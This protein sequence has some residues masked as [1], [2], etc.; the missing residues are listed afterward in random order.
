MRI[1]SAQ[2]ALNAGESRGYFSTV[3]PGEVGSIVFMLHLLVLKGDVKPVVKMRSM[4]FA[5]MG[6]FQTQMSLN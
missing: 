2:Y 3:T 1:N 5:F 4:F 6:G